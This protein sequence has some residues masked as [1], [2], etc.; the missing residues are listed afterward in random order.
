MAET[1][2]KAGS[3][4]KSARQHFDVAVRLADEV[5]AIAQDVPDSF[6]TVSE[7][8]EVGAINDE[9]GAAGETADYGMRT[10]EC[11]KKAK[12]LSPRSK[13]IDDRLKKVQ[14][15]ALINRRN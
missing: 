10:L 1:Q 9:L 7:V 14:E 4:R 5:M 15:I 8:C 6:F 11:M 3:P 12:A 13:R 2:L